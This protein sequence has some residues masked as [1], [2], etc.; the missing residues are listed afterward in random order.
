M[1][2]CSVLRL[3][4]Q[5]AGADVA[6]PLC[7]PPPTIRRSVVLLYP[8]E[9][10]SIEDDVSLDAADGFEVGYLGNECQVVLLFRGPIGVVL[11]LLVPCFLPEAELAEVVKLFPWGPDVRLDL[12]LGHGELELPGRHPFERLFFLWR[13]W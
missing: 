8:G 13:D 12:H 2:G 1:V 4:C 9:T 11:D 3:L 5:A 6:L 7:D 10:K